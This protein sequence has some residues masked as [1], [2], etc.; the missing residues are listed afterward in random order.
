MQTHFAP[1]APIAASAAAY[2]PASD[3]DGAVAVAGDA[4][5]P[6]N[7]GRLCVQGLGAG[8]TIDLEGRLLAPHDQRRARELG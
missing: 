4:E 7:F 1:P 2:S 6:A 5:H 8:E 3:A